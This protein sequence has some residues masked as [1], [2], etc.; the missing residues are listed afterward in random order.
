MYVRLGLK[1]D[2][3]AVIEMARSACAEGI[4]GKQFSEE[5]ARATYAQYLATAN[6]TI[7]V[8]E[9]AGQ[10][11]GVLMASISEYWFASG[12]FASQELL[13]VKPERRGSR[14]AALL[15]SHLVAWSKSLEAREITG[16][17]DN[18]LHND[19]AT[20]TIERFG[21]QRVGHFLKRDLSN[22]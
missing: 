2:E 5:V 10:V 19:I 17:A 18:G 21:F 1:S 12:H 15:L 20:R 6:P 8:V 4:T 9:S 11:V 3:D 14:A 22:G 16:G 13:F 7:F